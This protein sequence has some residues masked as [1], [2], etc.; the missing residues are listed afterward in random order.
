MLKQFTK[1]RCITDHPHPVMSPDYLNPSGC[2]KDNHTNAQFIW[3]IDNFFQ[4]QPY[5][6]LDIG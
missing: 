5:R 3:E 1:V 6:L 4:G 2:V